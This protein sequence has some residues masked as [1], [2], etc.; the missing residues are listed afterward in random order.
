MANMDI[1]RTI[2]IRGQ[3]QG[4]DTV[5]R[6]IEETTG[7]VSKLQETMRQGGVSTAGS[8]SVTKEYERLV[9]QVDAAANAQAKMDRAT[10]ITDRALA[11]GRIGVDEYNRTL[12]LAAQR[13]KLVEAGNDNLSGK[14]SL[15]RH[16]WI[17]LGRQ[18]NDAATMLMSGSSAFQV[19][20]TQGGQVLDVFTSSQAGFMGFVRGVGPVVGGIAALATAFGLGGKAA[21][22]YAS[23]QDEVERSLRGIG[24]MSGASVQGI[25]Q[26]ALD[27]AGAA[28]VS[29]ASAREMGSAFAATGRIGPALYGDLTVAASRY[30]KT[31]GTDVQ[32]ATEKMAQAFGGDV[33]QGATEL[34]KTLGFLS[35][36]TADLIEKQIAMG[37]RAGAQK[38]ALDAMKTSLTPIVAETNAWAAAWDGVARA[39]KNAYDATGRSI[40]SV[41]APTPAQTLDSRQSEMEQAQRALDQARAA[42]RNAMG[43]IEPAHLSFMQG[44]GYSQEQILAEGAPSAPGSVNRNIQEAEARVARLRDEVADIQERIHWT[45]VN[46]RVDQRN[47]DIA[48]LTLRAKGIVA[49]ITPSSADMLNL[50]KWKT[51]LDDALKTG[52]APSGTREA[53]AE[54]N[55]LLEQGGTQ[56]SQ[57]RDAARDAF[58][59]AGLLP[60]QRGLQEIENQYKRL[61]AVATDPKVIAGLN[62]AKDD[63]RKAFVVQNTDVVQR[64]YGMRVRETGR[65][66]DFQRDS[67]GQAPGVVETMRARMEML[68]DAARTGQD[69]TARY[70]AGWESL[71]AQMGQAKAAT[72]ELQRA[73]QNVI[74]GMDEM[75]SGSRG[76]FTGIFSDVRQGKSPLDGIVNS[77]GRMQDQMFDRMVSKPLVESVMGRDGTGQGGLLSQG[78]SGLMNFMGAPGSGKAGGGGTLRFDNDD[79][80]QEV[81][82]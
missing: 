42:G 47:A 67:F 12:G 6:V 78:F 19:F 21:L 35:G 14:L 79:A 58:N 69:V 55:R 54:V 34:N 32:S 25:N 33:L 57:M 61:I 46:A 7:K 27:Y 18:A 76:L 2:T 17:N 3:E 36:R 31:T 52:Q 77:L 26:T 28:K 53:L 22:D 65:N 64:D 72:D 51:T 82:A 13:F 75:R 49:Q 30:A 40:M 80:G 56:A 29:V 50:T 5:K 60:Y 45:Q 73:Q 81:A 68:N 39:A 43:S 44:R 62:A 10:R 16:E 37:D 15:Q 23:S 8:L 20:A 71:A 74:Q 11:Q 38:T 1:V 66:L 24:R 9:R 63:A 48:D 4:F 70:G 41:V 59:I